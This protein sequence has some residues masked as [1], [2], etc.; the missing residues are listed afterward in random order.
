MCEDTRNG[1]LAAFVRSVEREKDWNP[2]EG[3]THVSR[4]ALQE[5][6]CPCAAPRAQAKN[7]RDV[8][9]EI[10]KLQHRWTLDTSTI[11]ADMRYY[12]AF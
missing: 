10:H 6:I 4:T 12:G 1:S 9:R 11:I 5:S 3:V 8:R 7:K 2:T